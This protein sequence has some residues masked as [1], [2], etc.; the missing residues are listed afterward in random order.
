MQRDICLAHG[1][2]LGGASPSAYM[3]ELWAALPSL[4]AL[5]SFDGGWAHATRVAWELL[6]LATYGTFHLPV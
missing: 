3:D 1:Y 6:F 2:R 5:L 4:R